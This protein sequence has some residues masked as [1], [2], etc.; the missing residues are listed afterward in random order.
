[1]LV[2]TVDRRDRFHASCAAFLDEATEPLVV[3]AMVIFCCVDTPTATR[4]TTRSVP[5]RL[6]NFLPYG[7][8]R[9]DAQPMI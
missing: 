8:Q 9:T 3:P 2:A 1:V 7:W 5:P 6:S 4:T